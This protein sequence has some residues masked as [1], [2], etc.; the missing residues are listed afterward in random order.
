MF[1]LK[2]IS[3]TFVT[4]LLAVCNVNAANYDTTLNAAL[5]S[6]QKEIA[7]E[8]DNEL[9]GIA[10]SEDS[11][12]KMLYFSKMCGLTYCITTGSLEA[13]KTFLEGGC[14]AELDFCSN[15]D[16]N[17]SINRT[18]VEL[19]LEASEQELGT[20]F[21]A[22]DHGR[23][24]VMLSFRGSS[25]RQ[26]WFSDFEIYP[27]EYK[28]SSTEQYER[29]VNDGE[30]SECHNC[31][32]HKGFYRFIKT[33]SKDFLQRVERIFK[34]YPDYNLVVTGHS[35]GAALASICGIELKLRGHNP[36]ILTYATPKMFNEEMKNWVD[37][38]FG[39][40]D[41]HDECV[42]KGEVELLHG[43][44][45]V[46]HLQDY[47][48]MVPPGYKAAGLEIFITKPELPHEIHDLEYRAVGSGAT[49]N[50]VPTDDNSKYALMSGIGSW[51]HMDE[52]RKYFILINACSGF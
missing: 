42:E 23:E 12:E 21:V 15:I 39:T 8:D 37:E 22:V 7:A 38:L 6:S 41:I 31:M 46:I 20:G 26:D 10:I 19:I 9:K 43:Y 3:V 13:D 32:I 11:Y 44:F 36:L 33:L 52:H 48:P 34:R 50:K 45:R 14:P 17:P 4:L 25:T 47:I 49:W 29:L 28:P 24:V 51:L 2:W 16:L 27:T 1:S 18:R 5:Q 40:H 30:I 35:L